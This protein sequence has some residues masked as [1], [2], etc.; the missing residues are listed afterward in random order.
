MSA[1]MMQFQ[2][3]AP[4]V[5]LGEDGRLT[6]T[7]VDWVVWDALMPTHKHDR[8]AK[9]SRE[10]LFS[11]WK[12]PEGGKYLS[13]DEAE[14][15][16]ARTCG[17]D[18]DVAT[19]LRAP[20][21]RAFVITKS[22]TQAA[23][24]DSEPGS[25]KGRLAHEPV[26]STPSPQSPSSGAPS[27]RAL[28]S[29]MIQVLASE[30]YVVRSEFRIFL[31]CVKDDIQLYTMFV[32]MDTS[33]DGRLDVSEFKAFWPRLTQKFSLPSDPNPATEFV[34]LPR[35]EKGMIEYGEF[36]SYVVDL[37]LRVNSDTER[38]EAVERKKRKVGYGERRGQQRLHQTMP[39]RKSL[40]RASRVARGDKVK[41][42]GSHRLPTAAARGGKKG[43]KKGAGYMSKTVDFRALK[44]ATSRQQKQMTKAKR[45]TDPLES[46]RG[47]IIPE[48]TKTVSTE[49]AETA[50]PQ[51]T[52]PTTIDKSTITRLIDERISVFESRMMRKLND[53]LT[54]LQERSFSEPAQLD[55]GSNQPNGSP[56]ERKIADDTREPM[57]KLPT[58]VHGEH[59]VNTGTDTVNAMDDHSS[60]TPSGNGA[61]A[62]LS[63]KLSTGTSTPVTQSAARRFSASVTTPRRTSVTHRKPL[64]V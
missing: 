56:A 16:L 36:A 6:P 15:G 29:R 58:S 25:R 49:T 26:T 51:P 54:L 3:R 21:Q 41:G 30:Q 17:Y 47:A 22:M 62:H 20:L 37:K 8:A 61:A 40:G 44:H 35:N 53:I 10:A 24:R 59:Q 18:E 46:T 9:A 45:V 1:T 60:N 13:F 50:V 14:A 7:S 31:K 57:D 34:K 39:L 12:R 32:E 63:S 4:V 28:S 23:R 33:D 27:P 19:A 48:E 2:L 52:V 64:E 43:R 42:S 11:M 5:K 38:K 55:T